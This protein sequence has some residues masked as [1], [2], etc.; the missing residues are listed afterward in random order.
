[1]TMNTFRGA[2]HELSAEALDPAQIEGAAILYLE[3][4]L[5]RS[6]GAREAM[7]KAIAIAHKA[8]RRVA[9]TLSDIACIGPHRDDFMGLIEAGAIDLLFA[10]EA[11][12]QAL[13]DLP[14]RESAI[15]AIEDKVPLLVVTCGA[16]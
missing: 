16:D 13:A 12:I 14:D 1:R 10:N 5:W 8:G 6:S 2:A 7:R 11:E 3:A 9:L 4:Y 15:A